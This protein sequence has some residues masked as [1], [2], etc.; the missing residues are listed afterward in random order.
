MAE[1]TDGTVTVKFGAPP[2]PVAVTVT[3]IGRLPEPRPAPQP[4]RSEEELAH[5]H[6]NDL[7]RALF[8]LPQ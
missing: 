5:E 6:L 7:R 2:A 1:F 3:P 4:A 8:P